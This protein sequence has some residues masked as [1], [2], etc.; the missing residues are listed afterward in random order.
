[1]VRNQQPPTDEA[2]LYIRW[3]PDRS[4]YG[5]E[6]RLTLVQ[7]IS[8]Q[9]LL[10]E[11]AGTEFGG[12]LLGG[13]PATDVRTIRIDEIEMVSNGS[14]D[15]TVFLPEPSEFD[16]SLK[17]VD[18]LQ[19]VGFFRTHAREGPMRPSLADRTI[20]AHEFASS[21]HVVL[22]I[23]A[24]APHT[25]AFFVAQDSSLPQEPSVREF[26]FDESE[27]ASLPE[28]PPESTA[29]ES[30]AQPPAFDKARVGLY[31]RIAALIVIAVGACVLMWS[32]AHQ[33]NTAAWFSSDKQVHLAIDRQDRLL[34][35][36]WNHSA[37]DFSNAT[38][39]MLVITDRGVRSQVQLGTDDLRLGSVE[40]APTGA[41]VQVQMFVNTPNGPMQ[42]DSANWSG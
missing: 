10:S 13:L 8:R 26:I 36:S 5:I 12:Y 28:A 14:D 7:K 15:D 17:S 24:S 16:R 23:R 37:Q 35:I 29:M 32:F 11:N 25:A 31:L 3:G 42:A 9:V 40:Y 22:L 20:F 27:F 38:G 19:V 34:R 21:P 30:R 41:P 6:L 39:A 2:P 4:S 18:G 1:M 33:S